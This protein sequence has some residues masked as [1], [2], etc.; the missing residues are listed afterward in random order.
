MKCLFYFSEIYSSWCSFLPVRWWRDLGM[1]Q[2]LRFAR[3]QP[4]KWYMWPLA[5]LPN[6]KFSRY[7]IELT[8]PI[9][10]VYI[11]DDIYDVHGTLDEFV[12]F[13]EAVNR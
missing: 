12:Q 4:L 10:F 11:I 1:S 2:E 13:T 7:R 9:A 5:V 3:D 8:K 6:P